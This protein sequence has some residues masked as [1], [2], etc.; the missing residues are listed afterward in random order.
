LE[1]EGEEEAIKGKSK[2]LFLLITTS[3]LERV[4]SKKEKGQTF[5]KS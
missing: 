3:A 5:N 1:E 2:L 4:D